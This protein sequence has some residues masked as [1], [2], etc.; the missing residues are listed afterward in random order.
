M[1]LSDI[2]LGNPFCKA[3]SR[4]VEFLRWAEAEE[5]D[6]VIN[7]DGFE[8]AQVSF[9]KIARDVPD[10]FHAM[11]GFTKGGRALYYV[12]GNH[13][14]AFENLLDDWGGFR[15]APFL[16]LE[17]GDKRIRIE[18]GHL[19]DP[20]FV[21]Y[22]ELYEFLTW[23]AGFLLI[24]NPKLYKLWIQFEKFR[25][26]FWSKQSVGI[27]GEHPNFLAA[28]QELSN[29]GFDG[30]VFGHTHHAGQIKLNEFSRYVN[31]GS[32]LVGSDYIRIVDGQ[33]ELRKWENDR[34][35]L[36]GARAPVGHLPSGP[37]D[38]L[39]RVAS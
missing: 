17:S 22:P 7:G 36:L 29:R 9:T 14:M 5:F 23:L 27:Q 16:N 21:K 31:S 13:D 33:M 18:H 24:A 1:V 26:L 4:V 34:Q 37:H 28:A 35:L 6:V 20:F 30:V 3:R 38:S 10:V 11:K 32:W 2:H 25:S 8:I 15:V 39:E 19:Y 12:V